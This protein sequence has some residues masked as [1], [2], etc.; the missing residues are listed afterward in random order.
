MACNGK[1]K[2][3]QGIVQL[4]ALIANRTSRQPW[5][6]IYH[7]LLNLYRSM[8]QGRIN[9]LKIKVSLARRGC[10]LSVGIQPRHLCQ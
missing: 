1:N 8:A 10:G 5:N 6:W 7:L 2:Y 9:T 3:C 4:P